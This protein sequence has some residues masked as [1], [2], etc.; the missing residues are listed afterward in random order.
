MGFERIFC[1]RAAYIFVSGMLACVLCELRMHTHK[2]VRKHDT[3]MPHTRGH[4]HA[5]TVTRAS[6]NILAHER[7]TYEARTLA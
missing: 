2:H 7:N 3:N 6:Y 5:N 1:Q 4:T